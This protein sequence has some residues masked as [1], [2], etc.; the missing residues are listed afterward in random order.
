MKRYFMGLAVLVLL[1]AGVVKAEDAK[2]VKVFYDTD[3]VITVCQKG[4]VGCAHRIEVD[5]E[6]YLIDALG[7]GVREDFQAIIGA[8]QFH[9]QKRTLPGKVVGFIVKE[10]GH[11]PN[12]TAEFNVF[13]ALS[14]EFALPKGIKP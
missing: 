13:K 14:L 6:D 3:A 7:K 11:F 12:P 5:G 1:G 2:V 4:I 10:K 9:S 8:H